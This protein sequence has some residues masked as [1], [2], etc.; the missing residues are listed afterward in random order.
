MPKKRHHPSPKPQPTVHPTL[1]STRSPRHGASNEQSPSV[2]DLIRQLR[3]AQVSEQPRTAPHIAPRT[4]HPSLRNILGLPETPPPKPREARHLGRRARRTP[5]PAAP[6][7][8]TVRNEEVKKEDEEEELKKGEVRKIERLER[9]P[10]TSF[11]ALDSLTHAILKAMA[12]R[13]DYHL[14]YDNVFLSELPA[15]VKQM[16]L[17]YVARFTDHDRMEVGMK[18]LKPLFLDVNPETGQ[19]EDFSDVSRLDLGNAIGRWISIRQLQ[20]ELKGPQ[21]ESK[22]KS[23]ADSQKTQPSVEDAP[24]SWEEEVDDDIPSTVSSPDGPG[25][26][27][28]GRTLLAPYLTW[29]SIRP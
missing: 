4:V 2:N 28:P 8:W 12:M 18:G 15:Y 27:K 6:A 14:Q 3:R 19:P 17:S 23:M 5:G 10:G 21:R 11:P 16:L 1:Q 9:L 20:K 29:R 13:W 24:T 7:S 26:A 22:A 25:K